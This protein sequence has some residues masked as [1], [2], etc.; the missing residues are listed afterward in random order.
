[1]IRAVL[2]DIE[3]TTTSLSFVH[4]VLFP[5]SSE[6]MHSFIDD[7]WTSPDFQPILDQLKTQIP[8]GDPSA[9]AIAGLLQTWIDADKKEGTLKQIQGRI[10]KDAFESG[11]IRAHIYPD[12][13]EKWTEWKGQGLKIYIFS[14]GSV[15]AQQLLFRYSEA[16]DLTRYIDGYFDTTTGPKKESASYIKIANMVKIDPTEILFLSD[17]LAEL[18]A[19]REAGMKTVQLVRDS[20][21]PIATTFHN[22]RL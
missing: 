7:N 10:W 19:A 22:I 2:C 4:D 8:D 21:H 9:S 17:V 3:G 12:V 1:M 11:K 20:V 15:E 13:P 6:K 16:G 14:S 18:D 5:L